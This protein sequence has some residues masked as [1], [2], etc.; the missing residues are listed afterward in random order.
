MISWWSTVQII[1]PHI[2]RL[3]EYFV[4]QD[5]NEITQEKKP[6]TPTISFNMQIKEKGYC[7][8]EKR[9]II[10]ISVET[11]KWFLCNWQNK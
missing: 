7:I 2:L 11:E 1:S 5:K 9:K 4:F 3:C 10:S 8:K 6:N